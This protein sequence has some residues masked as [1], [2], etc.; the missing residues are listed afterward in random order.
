MAKRRANGEGTIYKWV[1]RQ[2]KKLKGL[3]ECKN[4]RDCTTRD[5]CFNREKCN[6]CDICK[7]CTDYKN[8][9]RY[10]F[11]D[12]YATQC[13]G[14]DG[15]R[16]APIYGKSKNELA[17]H[18]NKV[19]RDIQAGKYV[20]KTSATL[21]MMME[22]VIED[23]KKLNIT[24][25]SAYITNKA[26][27]KRLS[28]AEIVNKPVQKITIDEIKEYLS[29]ITEYSESII[30]KNYGLLNAGFKRAI[31]KGI[32]SYNPIQTS[33]IKKPRSKQPFAKVVALTVKEQRKFIETIHSLDEPHQYQNEWLLSIS[34]GMRMGE[35]LAL[36]KD[37]DIDFEEKIIHIN[38]TLTISQDENG[39][40]VTI[41]GDRTKTYNSYRDLKMS[42]DVEKILKVSM[43]QSIENENNLLFCRENGE[44]VTVNMITCALKR[45]CQKYKI[46]KN[47]KCTSHVLRHSFAT[48]QIESGLPA[49]I[50][51]K[52]LGHKSIKETL[53]TYTDV[54]AEYANRYDENV[55]D[56]YQKNGLLYDFECSEYEIVNREIHNLL[57]HL[58]NSHLRDKHKKQIKENL[59]DI[60]KWYEILE[61]T[62]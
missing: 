53:D 45:F 46:T 44:L 13:T 50:L 4:C 32:I 6:L 62:G 34:T 26:T 10:Y 27:L 47:K 43:E 54:F 30:K 19:S 55:Y 35:V 15:K 7:N 3:P 41:L 22:E 36:D 38:N 1:H 60:L 5:I 18:K 9:D 2:K 52:I 14:K 16:T 23:R 59:T 58:E 24:G 51:Q 49:H 61:N 20:G 42:P 33:E 31:A 17:K 56:Y 28:N 25:D 37:N 21:Y 29:T 40:E 12:G 48:R 57:S 8:C 39:K 11:Y